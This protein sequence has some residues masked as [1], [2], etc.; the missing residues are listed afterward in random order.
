MKKIIVILF[1]VHCSLFTLSR[2]EA[3]IINVPADYP[4]IQQGIDAANPGDTVLVS[5]G[6]YYGQISFLGKK[7]LMVASHFLVDGDTN[8]INNTIID[9]SQFT[10][11]D[12]ASVVA[13]KSGEDTTSILCGFTIRGGRG[14]WDNDNNNRCGGGI[15]ISGSGAKIIHNKITENTVD[16]TQQGNGQEAYGGGIGTSHEDADYWIVIEHNQIY[17]NTA[18]T[19]YDW[20]AGGGIYDSYNARIANN[21]ITENT[22]TSTTDGWG[23]GGGFSHIDLDGGAANTLIILNNKF[24]HN[25]AESISGYGVDGAASTVNTHLIFTGNEITANIGITA[26]NGGGMGGISVIDP[27]E[28]CIVSGNIFRENLGTNDGGAII[29]ENLSQVPNPNLVVIS[30]NYFLNNQGTYGGAVRVY[31]IPV[32]FQ[33]NVF[34]GNMATLNGGAIHMQKLTNYSFVHLVTMINNSFSGNAALN[35]GGAI[36][37]NK[38]KPLI[39]N[40]VFFGDEAAEGQEIYLNHYLDTMDI[41]Y[42]NIDPEMV[43]GNVIDAG[44]NINEDP[45]FLDD[46]CHIDEK[47]PCED[48][49]ADSV[50]FDG[51][52]YFAPATDFEGTPR[53]WHMG[54]DIGADEC[55]IIENIPKP[56]L[57]SDPF[58]Q[59]HI[60]PNPFSNHTNISYD[61][62]IDTQVEISLYNSQGELVRELLS[63]AQSKGSYTLEFDGTDLPAGIYF[64][65]ITAEGIGHK[66][67]SKLLNIK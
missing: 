23:S 21:V 53:P 4:T 8:H 26:V 16:D 35:L 7:P 46:T 49:G 43:Y 34:H 48:K 10:D 64:C 13:F 65:E 61:L 38:A 60:S 66:G 28:D 55:D 51:T 33:N 54:I 37:A 32:I 1:T 2:S 12:N 14:T 39:F 56:F 41:A 22:S 40:S 24:H 6:L 57:S 25:T 30:D 62:E 58:V 15:Y 63:C 52:W 3:Q 67:I 45:G 44:G 42:C 18:V 5:D 27:A 31:D 47:S 11:I 9:G 59:V 19:K 36:Y 17:N 20:S 29:L 50:N